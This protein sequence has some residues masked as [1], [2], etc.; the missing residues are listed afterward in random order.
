MKRAAIAEWRAARPTEP[1]FDTACVA[2]WVSLEFDPSG[3]VYG[4]CSSQM[5]PLGR[6]GIDRLSEIWS[7]P[8]VDALRHALANWDL[9]V[10]CGTCRW[11]LE[12]GR[13]DPVAAVYDRYPLESAYPQAPHMMLFALSNACNLACVMCNGELSSRIR[14]QEGRP[15]LRSPYTDE[16]F[17]DLEALLPSV[18]LTKFLG[19]EPF[20]AREHQRVW[21]LME[22]L[23]SQARV[24]VT[25][26]GTVWNDVVESVLGRFRTDISVSIDAATAATYERIRRGGDFASMQRNIER[27]L[28]ATQQAGTR[29]DVTYCLMIPNWHEL[30]AFLC[31][32]ERIG[33][34]ASINLVTDDGLALHDLPTGDLRS[35]QRRWL[36]EPAET[37]LTV[38]LDVWET[39]LRQLHMVLA[40]RSA[41][42]P[43]QQRQAQPATAELLS[44]RPVG[45]AGVELAPTPA[46]E[47]DHLGVWS[48]SAP[49]AE[50]MVDH[51]GVVRSIRSEHPALGLTEERVLGRFASDLL[52]VMSEFTGLR[53]WVADREAAEH[54]IVRTVVLSD[55]RPVRGSSATVVRIVEIGTEAGSVILMCDDRFFE[56]AVPVEVRLGAPGA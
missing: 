1:A 5:Y 54:R 45:S 11:H 37:R 48:G 7:G 51:A 34:R 44:D 6:I 30:F 35:I 33:V 19:G 24:E 41:G 27:F 10:A 47:R 39:Q 8:R 31:W 38:N 56:R 17:V 40:E 28:A 20:L 55:T 29:L 12:H 15:P 3:L 50:L 2:P 22:A 4:C 32:A 23:G 13:M 9:S 43:V 46:E 21:D 16:F 18:Q 42:S 26:N 49:V 53:V 52:V 14:A 36:G 25:T